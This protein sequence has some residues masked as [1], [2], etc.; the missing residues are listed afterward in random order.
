VKVSSTKLEP[1]LAQLDTSWE[2]LGERLE[3]MTDEEFL[4]EAAPGAHT[5]RRVDDRWVADPSDGP[6]VGSVRT[7]AWLAGHIGDAC[8][9]RADWTAGHHRLKDRELEWPGT[10]DDGVPFM[11]RGISAW[12]TA[13]GEMSDEDAMTVGRSRYPG[14]LDPTL[15]LI[16][17]VWWQNREVIHHGAE[18]AFLRD[19]Y[20]ASRARRNS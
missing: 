9:L 10:S 12:R 16:D 17:I 19:L 15:P 1:L 13:L 7:I 4:W 11:N 20:G 2:M 6:S 5:V 3:G 14:G 8:F 18:M